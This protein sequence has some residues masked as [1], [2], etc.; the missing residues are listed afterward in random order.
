[1]PPERSV[2][3]AVRAALLTADPLA[4]V[5]AARGAARAWRA[6]TL[7][8]RFDVEMPHEPAGAT[9]TT[10]PPSRM[11]KRGRGGSLRGRIAMLHALAHIEHAAID[12]ALDIVG[13][14]GAHFPRAFVDEWMRVAAEEAMHFALLARRL[15]RLGS[16]YGAL[17][18]HGG[19]WEAAEATME[20]PL[21]RLAVVP[22][23]LEARG[24]DVTPGTIARFE[25]A[26]DGASARLLG[27]ILADEIVHV[28]TGVRWFEHACAVQRVE[29]AAHWRGLVAAHFRGSVKPP[30]N[31][32]ARLSAGLTRD[33]YQ[34]LAERS[35]LNHDDLAP[36]LDDK[37]QASGV[38]R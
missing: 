14:F 38:N 11:P 17:P 30:F 36:T 22:M 12:L 9:A 21:A 10:S 32:S 23:V 16:V 15:V 20:D 1:M 6:G 8:W 34:S 5:K 28:A 31:A 7:A 25:A 27:R 19:L 33:Y 13:R 29:P 3:E 26:G 35:V 4:K 18:V 24:L 2:A 37:S